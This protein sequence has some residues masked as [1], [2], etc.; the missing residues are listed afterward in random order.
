MNALRINKVS[1]RMTK[2]LY[3]LRATTALQRDS[4]YVKFITPSRFAAHAYLTRHTLHEDIHTLTTLI[5]EN[6][7]GAKDFDGMFS[8]AA[9]GAFS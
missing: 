1:A 4:H 3:T 5:V 6:Q 8:T 9:L 7:I 2:F